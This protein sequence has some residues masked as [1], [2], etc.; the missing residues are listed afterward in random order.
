M[1]AKREAIK[2]GLPGHHW[3]DP[4]GFSPSGPTSATE[5]GAFQANPSATVSYTLWYDATSSAAV[6]SA[7]PVSSLYVP[8][9]SITNIT[10]HAGEIIAYRKDRRL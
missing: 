3:V 8:A 5:F 2:Y 4:S 10:V 7:G 9:F 1:S 6:S